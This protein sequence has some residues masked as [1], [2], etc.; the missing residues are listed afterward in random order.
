MKGIFVVSALALGG[1]VLSAATINHSRYEHTV[2]RYD[3]D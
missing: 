2:A 3:F 1:T